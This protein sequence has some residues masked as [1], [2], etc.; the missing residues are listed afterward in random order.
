MINDRKN[1]VIVFNGEI[2]NHK[3]LFDILQI[4]PQSKSD[5]EVIIHM[6]KKYGIEQ[7]LQMLDGVF[8][9]ILVDMEKKQVLAGLITK[10]TFFLFF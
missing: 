6:Y 8:A 9:F 1:C 2:Y 7:T 4:N 10:S 5:C 3:Q